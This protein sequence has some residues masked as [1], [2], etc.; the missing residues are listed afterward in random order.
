MSVVR[1]ALTVASAAV[2]ISH[3]PV[4]RAAVNN[5]KTREVAI[6]ATRI[7]AYNAGRLARAIVRPRAR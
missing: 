5:P 3:N 7:A 1:L 6:E 2:A 4:V